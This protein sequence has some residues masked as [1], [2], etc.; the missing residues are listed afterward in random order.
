MLMRHKETARVNR[1]M[2]E[3]DTTLIMKDMKDL[4]LST[5]KRKLN[6]QQ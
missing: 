5:T 3:I 2:W 4:I 6:A 1:A